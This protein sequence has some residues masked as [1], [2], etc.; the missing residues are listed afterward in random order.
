MHGKQANTSLHQQNVPLAS[1]FFLVRRELCGGS[2][3]CGGERENH[4][5]NRARISFGSDPVNVDG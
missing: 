1:C 3:S 2:L 4:R 5:F